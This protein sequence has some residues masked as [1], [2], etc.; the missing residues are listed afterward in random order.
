MG[1]SKDWKTT[2]VFSLAVL[3]YIIKITFVSL[4]KE[5]ANYTGH[6]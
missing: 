3:Y 2:G 6:R 5:I 1:G 4:K